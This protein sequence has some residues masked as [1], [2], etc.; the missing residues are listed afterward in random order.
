M[1]LRTIQRWCTARRCTPIHRSTIPLRATTPPEWRSHSVSALPW[2]RCGA[3]AGDGAAAGAVTTSTSTLTTT[4][5][6]TRISTAATGTT[7]TAAT[8]RG[9]CPPAEALAVL[10]AL[11]GL[12]E[13]GALAELAGRGAL[14]ELVASEA[15][16]VS[17]EPVATGGSTT[18]HI[19]AGLRTV[20]ATRRTGLADRPAEIHCRIARLAPGIRL[21]GRA[22]I[23]P[24]IAPAQAEPV[25]SEGLLVQAELAIGEGLASTAHA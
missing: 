21:A 10:E 20:I 23:C 15:L 8:V 1:Y 4:S 6:A 9:N 12:A 11:G 22:A 17:A 3:A 19:A 18:L 14:V 5:I 2:A 16:E 13:L 7:S 25:T 24:A